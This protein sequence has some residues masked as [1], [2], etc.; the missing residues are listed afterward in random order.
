MLVYFSRGDM[1]CELPS[2]VAVVDIKRDCGRVP[3]C[4]AV[5]T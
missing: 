2:L 5:I 1:L 4:L 3:V